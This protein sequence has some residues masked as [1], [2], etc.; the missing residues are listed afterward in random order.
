MHRTTLM[1]PEELRERLRAVAAARGVSMATIVREALEEK[2]DD[3]VRRPRSIG[4]VAS[5]HPDTARRSTTIRPTPRA[6]R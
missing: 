4:I 2:I 5:G 3:P 1:L 6:W